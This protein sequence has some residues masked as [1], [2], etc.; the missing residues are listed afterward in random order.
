MK[1]LYITPDV[2]IHKLR[3]E[4]HVLTV[5]PTDEPKVTETPQTYYE[6]L[7]AEATKEGELIPGSEGLSGPIGI[8]EGGQSR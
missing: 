3:I 1:K 2:N 7:E 8:W 6:V 4:S 5:S